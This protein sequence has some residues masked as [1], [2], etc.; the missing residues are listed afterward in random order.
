[1]LSLSEGDVK[2]SGIGA[3]AAVNKSR[4]AIKVIHSV[5]AGLQI[6]GKPNQN[7]GVANKHLAYLFL[8]SKYKM[9]NHFQNK[10]SELPL[11][12]TTVSSAPAEA[13]QTK[14]PNTEPSPCSGQMH[15]HS[16]AEP[17]PLGH[18]LCFTG[19]AGNIANS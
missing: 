1:M 19:K 7:M 16:H 12:K 2:E 3:G 9:L 11:Q 10:T 15:P 17:W 4:S 8:H 13:L 6:A 14:A 18:A 5:C